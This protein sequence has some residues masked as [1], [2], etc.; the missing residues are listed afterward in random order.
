MIVLVGCG[1]A[2]TP[3]AETAPS[4]GSAASATPGAT[5]QIAQ[6][7]ALLEKASAA[8]A[9]SATL[10]TRTL[11]ANQEVV[12]MTGKVNFNDGELNGHVDVTTAASGDTPASQVQVVMTREKQYVRNVGTSSQREEWLEV[13]ADGA[14][15]IADLTGYGRLLLAQGPEAVKGEET[16]GTVTATRLSGVVTT[17]DVR[18]L[19]PNLYNRLRTAGV[20]SFECDIWVDGSGRTVRLEQ[21][22]TMSGYPTHNVMEIS[23]FG[24]A[25]EQEAPE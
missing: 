16:V 25:F 18:T 7:D 19:E 9:Y 14:S 6:L 4:A 8:P 12:V 3:K 13:P 22:I 5:E 10:T 1:S 23:E 15:S 20:E 2:S 11:V 17:E 24:S 21:W